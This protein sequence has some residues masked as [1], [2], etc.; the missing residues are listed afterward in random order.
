MAYYVTIKDFCAGHRVEESFVMELSDYE[1]IE[2]ISFEQQHFIH[3]EELPKLERM[4]RLQQDL[5]INL[6]G[7]GAIVHLLDK[8]ESLE[9]EVG[10]LRKRL[11]SFYDI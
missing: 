1:L 8:I 10:T 5:N 9:N 3:F 11:Q 6:E 2:V 4:L 7:I